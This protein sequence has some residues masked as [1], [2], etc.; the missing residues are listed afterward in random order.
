MTTNTAAFFIQK[1]DYGEEG[2]QK[3]LDR[4]LKV[5]DTQH[6]ELQALRYGGL[7]YCKR[8]CHLLYVPSINRN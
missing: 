8:V 6:A 3:I 7:V 2:G 5:K 1:A 4:A